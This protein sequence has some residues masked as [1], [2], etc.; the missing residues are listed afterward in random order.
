MNELIDKKLLNGIN[1]QKYHPYLYHLIKV[2]WFIFGSLTWARDSRR[3]HSE[4]AG[5]MRR[6]DFND[7][8]SAFCGQLKLRRRNL[9][10]YKATEFGKSGEPHYHFLIAKD[11]CDHLSASE[12]A[13][14][15]TN[16]WQSS[17]KP[18]GYNERGIGMAIIKPYDEAKEHPAA[19]YCLKR[20]FDETGKE[21]ERDDFLSSRLMKLIPIPETENT[22]TLLSKS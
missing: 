8:I 15:L 12:C 21:W 11:G 3:T 13:Q 19:K 22:H 6:I 18:Y 7:L 4:S 16:L 20:E 2:E 10:I 14:R 1:Y 17:L 9:G 5:Q